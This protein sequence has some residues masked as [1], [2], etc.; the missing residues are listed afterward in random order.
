MRKKQS[1]EKPNL[2]YPHEKFQAMLSGLILSFI[3]AAK[4][5]ALPLA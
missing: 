4:L 2:C 5:K 3:L 1:F